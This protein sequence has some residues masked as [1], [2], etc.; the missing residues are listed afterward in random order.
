MAKKK[1]LSHVNSITPAVDTE[2]GVLYDVLEPGECFLR[3]GSLYMKEVGDSQIGVN[4]ATGRYEDC[5][6]GEEVA[7]VSIAITWKKK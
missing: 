1:V 2:G 3:N 7:P 6:C 5:L 4:L